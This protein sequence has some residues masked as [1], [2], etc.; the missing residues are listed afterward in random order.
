MP[1][2]MASSSGSALSR[3]PETNQRVGHVATVRET[4]SKLAVAQLFKICLTIYG[5]VFTRI[6]H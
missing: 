3:K 5:S 4:P 6:H 1:S 2:R